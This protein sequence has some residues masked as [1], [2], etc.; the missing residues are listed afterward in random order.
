MENNNKDLEIIRIDMDSLEATLKHTYAN[1]WKL[2]IENDFL[3]VEHNK[4]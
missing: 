2:K 4:L 3:N 1:Y